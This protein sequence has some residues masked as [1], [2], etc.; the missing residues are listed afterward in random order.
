MSEAPLYPGNQCNR[1]TRWTS[2]V[3]LPVNFEG[4]V[5]K[6]APVRPSSHLHGGELTFDERV[7]VQRV[8]VVLSE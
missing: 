6:F 5:T 4:Y 3:S 2:R 1:T 7:V 8:E